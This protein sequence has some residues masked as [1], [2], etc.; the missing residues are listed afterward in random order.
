[1]VTSDSHFLVGW[2]M[3]VISPLRLLSWGVMFLQNKLVPRT[4]YSEGCFKGS[5]LCPLKYIPLVLEVAAMK[6]NILSMSLASF[7][8][9]RRL[10]AEVHPFSFSFLSSLFYSFLLFLLFPL[11]LAFA[12]I[13]AWHFSSNSG[14]A[15]CHRVLSYD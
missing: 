9:R 5:L 3:D 10:L 12:C 2:S 15:C 8:C 13:M 4:T 14:H 1:M 6:V 7:F 11:R